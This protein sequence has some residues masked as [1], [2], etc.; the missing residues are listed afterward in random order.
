MKRT[1]SIFVAAIAAA[2]LAAPAAW[3]EP[4]QLA[5]KDILLNG[6]LTV[7]EGQSVHD[8]VILITHGSLA[9][10]EMEI[11]VA[12]REA[13]AERGFA[14]L[15]ISL[16]FNRDDRK[17]FYDCADGAN[18]HKR[19]DAADEI[20]AWV[21]WLKGQGADR[22]AVMGHSAGGNQTA[23]YGA[24]RRD[25]A[26][27]A[28]ILLAP[29]SYNS[30]SQASSYKSR[31][32][33]DLSAILQQAKGMA[34]DALLE[35]VP[36]IRCETATVSAASFLSYYEPDASGDTA[37]VA[38]SIQVPVLVIAGSEDNVVGDIAATF[39]PRAGD[40]LK[41]MMVE[42][43]DHFFLDLYMEDVADAVSEFLEEHW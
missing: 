9:H 43:A 16:S 31:F 19:H 20:A 24:E 37:A 30:G 13:L 1:M 18:T 14:S 26:V 34:P 7:P 21:D 23:I 41:F 15:A 33:K 28:V 42:G 10:H 27:G 39:A 4:V 40:R 25:P 32:G 35:G 6:E 36:F 12:I 2:G 11:V 29:G 8:G 3:A 5:Y 17:G 22:I 38:A